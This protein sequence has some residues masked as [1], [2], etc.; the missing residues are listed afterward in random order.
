MKTIL[1]S[2][3]SQHQVLLLEKHCVCK[4]GQWYPACTVTTSEIL[5]NVRTSKQKSSDQRLMSH[6]ETASDA[7]KYIKDDDEYNGLLIHQLGISGTN[8]VEIKHRNH[9]KTT[10]ATFSRLKKQRRKVSDHGPNNVCSQLTSTGLSGFLIF[11]VL[12]CGFYRSVR[13]STVPRARR[14]QSQ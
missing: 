4:I 5:S 9:N 11:E 14:A 2:G 8:T 1:L 7:H 10:A 12:L 3:A 6:G 13:R